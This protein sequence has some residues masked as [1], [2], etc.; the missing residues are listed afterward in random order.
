MVHRNL[1]WFQTL[2]AEYDASC[3]DIDPFQAMAGGVGGV[4]PFLVGKF[5]E[6]P[7]TLP[8]D[9]TLFIALGDTTNSIWIRKLEYLRP[10]AGMALM[11]THPDYLMDEHCVDA[12]RQFLPARPTARRLLACP[13]TRCRPLVAGPRTTADSSG[14]RRQ[15]H[16]RRGTILGT[17]YAGP[18]AVSGGAAPNPQDP[19]RHRP[20]PSP[21]L[22]RATH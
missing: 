20:R 8:Q 12:Y 9:H 16:T 14:R 15:Q 4:W 17:E 21:E 3:F 5:V 22:G 2:A 7:Y 6:L 18:V 19:N 1:D 13:A 10:L 11:L